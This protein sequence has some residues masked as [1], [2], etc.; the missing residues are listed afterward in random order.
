MREPQV[1]RRREHGKSN[2]DRRSARKHG[3]QP[4]ARHRD[5]HERLKRL[6]PEANRKEPAPAEFHEVRPFSPSPVEL[7][8]DQAEYQQPQP[9]PHGTRVGRDHT[10]LLDIAEIYES[11]GEPH[12][13][14][15]LRHD[16]IGIAAPGPMMLQNLGGHRKSTRASSPRTSPP[17]CSRGTDRARRV[18]RLAACRDAVWRDRSVNAVVSGIVRVRQTSSAKPTSPSATPL[19][20]NRRHRGPTSAHDGSKRDNRGGAKNHAAAA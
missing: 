1:E 11:Q 16:R 13:E 17:R 9:A 7:I 5:V 6:R 12:R 14:E 19:G 4:Q 20:R 15:K 2:T 18:V 8:K 3:H 10:Q